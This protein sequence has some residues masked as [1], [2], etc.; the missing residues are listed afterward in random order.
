MTVQMAPWLG[1]VITGVFVLL[2]VVIA[3]LIVLH[4]DR[5]R[6]RREDAYRLVEKQMD[7]YVQFLD[8]GDTWLDSIRN[9]L[10][11][12]GVDVSLADRDLHRSYSRIQIAGESEVSQAATIVWIQSLIVRDTAALAV[13]SRS[14]DSSAERQRANRIRAFESACEMF[15]K[16]QGA[17]VREAQ[18]SLGVT[19]GTPGPLVLPTDIREKM[20]SMPGYANLVRLASVT[21]DDKTQPGPTS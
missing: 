14:L 13:Q 2:G 1:P 4:V 21:D 10:K 9:S 7:V 20:S 19:R 8:A 3:Q 18:S 11:K 15:E 16:V 6:R 5:V 17:F 12:E